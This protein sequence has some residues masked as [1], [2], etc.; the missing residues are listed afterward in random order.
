MRDGENRMKKKINVKEKRQRQKKRNRQ[1]TL[2]LGLGIL[3]VILVVSVATRSF[4][5]KEEDTTV[6]N[7]GIEIIHKE[8]QQDVSAIE[9]EIK[10]LEN[11][12]SKEAGQTE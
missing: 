9:E 2:L 11:G 7:S 10:R 6:T 1:K 5:G 3:A 12:S 8:E 4:W